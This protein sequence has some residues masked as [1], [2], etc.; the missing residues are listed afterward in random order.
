MKNDNSPVEE[1]TQPEKSLMEKSS[2]FLLKCIRIY[3]CADKLGLLDKLQ[4]V[5]CSVLL[6]FLNLM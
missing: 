5:N 3:Y 6:D 2:K 1:R 4:E